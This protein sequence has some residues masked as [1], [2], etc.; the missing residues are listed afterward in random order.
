MTI[1]RIAASYRALPRARLRFALMLALFLIA[2]GECTVFTAHLALN[3]VFFGPGLM[4]GMLY[5]LDRRSRRVM[6]LSMMLAVFA[7]ALAGGLAANRALF[8]T[9][10]VGGEALVGA[11]VLRKLAPDG[12][13]LSRFGAIGKVALTALLVVP[14]IGFLVERLLAHAHTTLLLADPVLAGDMAVTIRSGMVMRWVL[15]HTL[16][17]VLATP[18][19]LGFARF[20]SG[21]FRN[22]WSLERLLTLTGSA[23]STAL[24]FYS[25]GHAYLFLICPILVWTGLRLGIR[26]TALAIAISLVTASFATAG[27]HGPAEVLLIPEPQ[28]ALFLELAYLCAYGCI[29]P[30]AASLETRRRLELDVAHNLEFT[31][32]ILRNVTEIVF[33]TDATGKWTFLNPAWERITGF[34]LRE[35]LAQTIDLPL[36]IDLT[37]TQAHYA[38]LIDGNVEE[39][40]RHKSFTRQDGSLREVEVRMQAIRDAEGALLGTT[41]TIRDVSEEARHVAELEASEQRFRNLANTAPIGILRCNSFGRITYVNQRFELICMIATDMLIGRPWRE[42]LGLE[43][44]YLADDLTATL[45]VPGAVFEREISFRD[46]SGLLRW[47]ILTATGEFDEQGK[48]SAYVC[49][50]N[51]ITQRKSTEIEL[52]GRTSELQLLAENLNDM[53]FRIGLDGSILYVTPSVRAILGHDPHKIIGASML[54]RIHPDDK[55]GLEA[56]FLELISGAIDETSTTY[57]SLPNLPDADYVWLE[58]NC[59]L[60]RDKDGRPV[61]VVASVRDITERKQLEFD[62]TKARQR[63]EDAVKAKSAF[64]ANLSHEIRTPMNGVIG[65][66]ELLLE[67]ELEPTSRHYAELIS[68]SGATMMKLLNDILDISKIDAGRLQLEREPFDLHHCLAS[69]L[70]LM[71]ASAVSK[72]LDLR[73]DIATDVPSH[74]LGDSLRVRQMLANLVGNAVKFTETGNV[75]LHARVVDGDLELSVQDTGIGIAPEA[76]AKVF[77]EFVQASSGITGSHGGT[78][79]GLPISRRIAEAMGGSLTLTSQPGV[80]TT[81]TIRIPATFL[82]A[83]VKPKDAPPAASTPLAGACGLRVLVAEDNRTNQII[84]RAMLEQLGHQVDIA[85]DGEE[86]IA[87]VE[88]AAAAGQ[89]YDVVLMDLLMPGMDGLEATREL[90]ARHFDAD[91]L[92]IVALTAN[93][94]QEDIDRCM[95]A[96]MQQHL[97]KPVRMADLRDVLSVQ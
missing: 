50:V 3:T 96:G 81:M 9:F 6:L 19:T 11:V 86:V 72:G 35:S 87:M 73:L 84:I 18:L 38:E 95:E 44:N 36:T 20:S 8:G 4:L 10:V 88:R 97:T 69:T 17:V 24:V 12:L 49:A 60:R 71:T 25:D 64:L 82:E 76:Q 23:V 46:R 67:H 15:P 28:R 21:K 26:D 29:L 70:R 94:F 59:R 43:G 48:L 22:W 79:L 16:G 63:A 42:V 39:V 14:P 51:D 47:L 55:D 45:R 74:M 92:R 41:G 58:T 52:A 68:E 27:G 31:E 32:Q 66:T 1:R 2:Y 77:D 90:R 89:L 37:K 13:D 56:V 40:I 93:G 53:I 91:R 65:L 5:T 61:E 30:I 85:P 34:T 80:G 83:P 57:R 62:L 54:S 33:R 78:G 7:G 75:T